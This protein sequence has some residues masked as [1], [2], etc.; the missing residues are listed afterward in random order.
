M[1]QWMTNLAFPE[2]QEQEEPSTLQWQELAI[3]IGQGGLLGV[4]R[5]QGLTKSEEPIT[6]YTRVISIESMDKELALRV[7]SKFD[8]I[9]ADTE[10]R[11]S[12][13]MK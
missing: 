13:K 3:L 10:F 1:L 9:I 2:L 4:F 6:A 11:L 5:I 8:E 7:Y 12:I